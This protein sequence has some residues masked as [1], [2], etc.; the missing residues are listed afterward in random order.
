MKTLK[1]FLA[2]TLTVLMIL[3]ITPISALAAENCQHDWETQSYEYLGDVKVDG[4]H[5]CKYKCTEKCKKCGKIVV[6]EG[7]N[8]HYYN[9]KV[10]LNYNDKDE[11]F[12]RIKRYY[13]DLV[14][15]DPD[16]KTTYNDVVKY[17]ESFSANKNGCDAYYKVCSGCG[18]ED[19]EIIISNTKHKWVYKTNDDYLAPTCSNEGHE[20]SVTQTC[21]V[22]KTAI[23]TPGNTIEKTYEHTI[24]AVKDNFGKLSLINITPNNCT[25]DAKITLTDSNGNSYNNLDNRCKV[26]GENVGL[27]NPKAIGHN[28]ISTTSDNGKV[29]TTICSNKTNTYNLYLDD[30]MEEGN[31]ENKTVESG[32]PYSSVFDFD[33]SF[34]N[35]KATKATFQ[36]CSNNAKV[37]SNNEVI[38]NKYI[39]SDYVGFQFFSAD[40]GK[41]VKLFQLK[42]DNPNDVE[43]SASEKEVEGSVEGSTAP[44]YYQTTITIT[45]KEPTNMLRYSLRNNEYFVSSYLRDSISVEYENCDY[46]KVTETEHDYVETA[47]KD[48][49]CTQKGS[50]TYTC[51]RCGDTYTDELPLAEHTPTV[52]NKVD[53]TCSKEGYTGDTVCSVCNTLI[54]KG[55]TVEKTTHDYDKQIVKPTCT[56]QGYTIYTCKDCNYSYKGDYTPVDENNHTLKYGVNKKAATCSEEGYTGDTVCTACGKTVEKGSAIERV[57]HTYVTTVVEPNCFE[58]GY[59]LHKCSVCNDTYKSDFTQPDESK[60]VE[61][62]DEGYPA[63]C[64]TTGLTDGSHCSV[65]GNVLKEQ[66]VINPLGHDIKK[67]PAVEATCINEGKTAGE[68]CM[69]EGCDYEIKQT[70]IPKS[71]SHVWDEGVTSTKATCS[72][73]GKITYTCLICNK[74]K[75]LTIAKLEHSFG[76]NSPHCLVCGADNPN[77][78]APTVPSNPTTKPSQPTTKPSTTPSTSNN[79]NTVAPTQPTQAPASPMPTTATTTVSK[80]KKTKIKKVKAAKKAVAV[81]WNKVSGVSGYEVQVATDKKFKKNKKTV[82]IKKQKTTSTTV[83]KLKAKKKYYVRV[84]T[85]KTVNGKKVYS[86][87]SSVKSVKTK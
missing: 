32:E 80:P 48:S 24:G 7:K 8:D 40:T 58:Q 19:P 4:E 21:S 42:V 52:I 57:P 34:D 15:T 72:K 30:I 85:Y 50:V 18:F 59:T 43:Y 71:D 67:F 41:A 78:V 17:V 28:L 84:R 38:I 46:K 27:E 64:T 6:S 25:N 39:I 31:D 23:T 33:I 10:Y 14:D 9:Q 13:D 26:C 29:T 76:N 35:I 81:T 16:T 86:S 12:K 70:V 11:C 49:T 68:K 82:T 60:H 44:I 56:E 73:E 69:R 55:S 61:V 74:T 63:T 2:V 87:W 37:N 5:Y 79:N 47:R 22:C 77:Y 75:T 66:E 83:K 62:I 3:S 53:A 20:A 54:S 51:S 36:F 1:K 65:C 45:F